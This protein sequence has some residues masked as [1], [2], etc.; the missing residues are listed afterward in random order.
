VRRWTVA[1]RD[2]TDARLGFFEE[3]DAR[4]LFGAARVEGVRVRL[5]W[6]GD[7][8]GGRREWRQGMGKGRTRN[9]KDRTGNGSLPLTTLISSIDVT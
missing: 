6:G 5:V 8:G 7:H 1:R 4:P 3:C 9:G 2:G